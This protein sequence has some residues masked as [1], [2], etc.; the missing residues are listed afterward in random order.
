MEI[1]KP[2]AATVL[3]AFTAYIL[4][5]YGGKLFIDALPGTPS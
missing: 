4:D 2:V 3:V 5:Y 1:K